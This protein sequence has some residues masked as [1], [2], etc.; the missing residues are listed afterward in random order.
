MPSHAHRLI[1]LLGQINH[2][3]MLEIRFIPPF[4]LIDEA[5]VLKEPIENIFAM[6]GSSQPP[7]FDSETW[8]WITITL[9]HTFLQI[10][11]VSPSKG[12]YMLF[13]H[14]L[15]IVKTN[16]HY[17]ETLNHMLHTLVQ[18]PT[19]LMNE[20]RYVFNQQKPTSHDRRQLDELSSFLEQELRIQNTMT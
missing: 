17:I 19:S 2:L 18:Q 5:V 8:F 13:E 12:S 3:S 14:D 1:Y 11:A 4:T 10:Q 9:S 15:N 20:V 16:F 6:M 7:W